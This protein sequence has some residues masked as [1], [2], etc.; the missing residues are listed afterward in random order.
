MRRLKRRSQTL[1]DFTPVVEQ[2]S[3]RGTPQKNAERLK[4]KLIEYYRCHIV[5]SIDVGKKRES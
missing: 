4:I 1:A 3:L 5:N 2:S